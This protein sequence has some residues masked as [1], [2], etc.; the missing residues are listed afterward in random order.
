MWVLKFGV[1][2]VSGAFG[3]WGSDTHN[4][5]SSFRLAELAIWSVAVNS[6]FEK[7]SRMAEY[8]YDR[9]SSKLPCAKIGRLV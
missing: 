7:P 2:G 1:A 8:T 6:M 4:E 3:V 9:S 5:L